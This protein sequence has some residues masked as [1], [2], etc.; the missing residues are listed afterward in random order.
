MGLGHV[1]AGCIS[2][3]GKL[4][5]F[6]FFILCCLALQ[7]CLWKTKIFIQFF[8]MIEE[9]RV[10][11][12]SPWTS[13]SVFSLLQHHTNKPILFLMISC[14]PNT[15]QGLDLGQNIKPNK[16]MG[17]VWSLDNLNMAHLQTPLAGD[18]HFISDNI[19]RYIYF[20]SWHG[21]T[22]VLQVTIYPPP[23]T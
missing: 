19:I 3:W 8:L 16:L 20:Q 1:C 7:D 12:P 13:I 4:L 15:T 18:R 14:M 21:G 9:S 5:F 2:A 10:Q 11:P 17:L 6:R 23:S 22:D